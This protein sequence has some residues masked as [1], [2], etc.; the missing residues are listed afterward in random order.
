MTD[1][2][3]W[4]S[5]RKLAKYFIFSVLGPGLPMILALFTVPMLIRQLGVERYALLNIAWL[6]L[7]YFTL[8]D[9]GLG[10]A[11]VRLFAEK[12]YLKNAIEL[13]SVYFTTFFV[14][15][16]VGS[17]LGLSF[18]VFS[19]FFIVHFFKIGESLQLEAHAEIFCLAFA[20][21]FVALTSIF[22]GFLEVEQKFLLSNFLQAIIGVLTY[23]GPIT[24][25]YFKNS[26]VWI[27][28]IMVLIR[29]LIFLVYFFLSW[30]ALPQVH[31]AKE[32]L[33]NLDIL[34]QLLK[35]GS[36]VTV[37]NLVGPIITYSDRMLIG[38][39]LSL[40]AVAYYATPYDLITRVWIVTGALNQVLFPAFSSLVVTN[41]S[42]A[43]TLY[44]F[45]IKGVL[46]LTLPILL[47]ACCFA[48]EVL[49]FWVGLDF[50]TQS[51][52]ILQVFCVGIFFS[53]LSQISFV[54]LQSRDRA[55]IP[56]KFH[57]LELVF[58]ISGVFLAAKYF[59]LI[60]V[61]WVWSLRMLLD[62]L[63]LK[64]AVVNFEPKL[65]IYLIQMIKSG[66]PF[67]ICLLLF[68]IFNRLEYR[69]INLFVGIILYARFVRKD[70]IAGQ[71][72]K[73]LFFQKNLTNDL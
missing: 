50:A 9:L 72:I 71:N 53:I 4:N 73:N 5:K 58:F 11:A 16:L 14:S 3:S 55:D 37:S 27:V 47:V 15:L 8:F 59:G 64:F 40:S 63:L 34:K 1:A 70:I 54:Y 21:P 33:F 28:G 12:L 19:D 65:R 51:F 46:T 39:L 30:R 24:I 57:L 45:A 60:G 6:I 66:A 62:F 48:F 7:G 42:E 61:A 2:A 49:K 68:I 22:R 32:K 26:L 52:V 41:L 38:S 35:M 69:L 25:I 10:R 29:I 36:W 44:N 67:L 23:L 56:A 31:F 13:R 43:N 18:G 17:A 20:I